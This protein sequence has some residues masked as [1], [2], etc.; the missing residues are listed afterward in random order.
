M[1][2]GRAG[3]PRAPAARARRP[4]ASGPSDGT[5]APASSGVSVVDAS[6]LSKL[7]QLEADHELLKRV[8][9]A[10][11]QTCTP[12]EE[13]PPEHVH[14]DKECQRLGW[15]ARPDALA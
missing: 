13:A 3:R 8:K 1:R 14:V 15:D 6:A 4:R 5:A 7:A 11:C 9:D 10:Q 2:C 12:I